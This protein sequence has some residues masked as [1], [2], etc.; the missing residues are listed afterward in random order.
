MALSHKK[1]QEDILDI[2]LQAK[3]NIALVCIA[4]HDK[5]FPKLGSW[6]D[7]MLSMALFIHF[8]DCVE[9]ESNAIEQF[10]AD[11]INAF[12]DSIIGKVDTLIISCTAGKCRSTAIKAA[13]LMKLFG[14]DDIV[15]NDGS[16][17]PNTFVYRTMLKSFMDEEE[18]DI[19]DI[20][21]KELTNIEKWKLVND[22]D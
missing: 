19:V 9:N 13:I 7:T 10:Q 8:D 22:L 4:D 21:S 12:V 17:C 20:Q 16:V 14:N 2:N 18:L 11:L 15:W 5:S 6:S 3:S 1:I